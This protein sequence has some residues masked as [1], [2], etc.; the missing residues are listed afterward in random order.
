MLAW[1]PMTTWQSGDVRTNGI[2]M[3]YYRT[4]GDKPPL[5]LA[6]GATD[7]GLC[8]TRVARALEDDYDVI[9][10][11]ARGHGL[12]DAPSEG[13]SSADHAADLAGLTRALGLE[14]P[15]V[16]GHSMGAGATLH[17]VSEEPDLACCAF[18]EDPPLWAGD[19]PGTPP[20]GRESARESMRRM[21]DEGR[22]NGRDALIKLGHERSPMWEDEEF[23]PWADA[24]LRLSPTFLDSMR[25]PFGSD[26][27]DEIARVRCPL[28]LITSDHDKGGIVTPQVSEEAQRCLPALRVVHL[29]GAGHNIR[30]EQFERFV[31]CVREF[32]AT[33]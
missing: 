22:T 14:R 11:D 33:H 5:V 9:M 32:L 6:H 4:G 3:H 19:G 24:K 29:E 18:L 12:S 16:G 27:R 17:L 7:D 8:W 25:G 2:R 20:P 28:L 31:A 15:A 30:R 23:G 1:E 13:Y 10:P 21:V 26:W